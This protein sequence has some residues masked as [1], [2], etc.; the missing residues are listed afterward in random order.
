[1]YEQ[2]ENHLWLMAEWLWAVNG[3]GLTEDAQKGKHRI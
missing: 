2:G 3:L 1:M